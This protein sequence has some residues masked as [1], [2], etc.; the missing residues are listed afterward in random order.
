MNAPITECQS[1]VH[2][3]TLLKVGGMGLL[4][5]TMPKLLHAATR[6]AAIAPRA[7]SVIFLFQ[8]GG[9]SQLDMLDMKPGAPDGIRSPYQPIATSAPGIQVCEHLPE[10]AKR[11][12]QVCLIRSLT[13]RM[14]NHASAGYYA[15]TG[16]EPPSDDDVPITIDGRRLD[17]PEKVI[18]FVE[19]INARR[20]ASQHAG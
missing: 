6:P 10:L 12:D 7:K 15:I 1:A 3:R 13:H 20:A 5:L 19:E 2:R 9:P 17:T 18:A 4:G 14:K 16:H 11:M 8:W